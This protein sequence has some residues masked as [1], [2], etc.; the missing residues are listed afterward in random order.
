M[1]TPN[2]CPLPVG[3]AAVLAL[4]L[5]F[6]SVQFAAA[7][8]VDTDHGDNNGA[9]NNRFGSVIATPP[10]RIEGQK[11]DDQSSPQYDGAGITTEN[12]FDGNNGSGDDKNRDPATGLKTNGG[13]K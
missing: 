12:D 3:A 2:N 13:K 9:G 11:Y 5:V 8:H 10:G 7:D 1:T 6:S 4:G